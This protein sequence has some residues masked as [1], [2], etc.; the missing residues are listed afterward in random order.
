LKQLPLLMAARL[1]SVV[2]ADYAHLPGC[3]T[4]V[5][6]LHTHASGGPNEIEAKAEGFRTTQARIE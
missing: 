4:L 6:H 5:T 1:F 3:S 2:P